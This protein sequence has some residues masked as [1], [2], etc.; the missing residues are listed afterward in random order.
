MTAMVADR[1]GMNRVGVKRSV[2][3]AGL[4]LIVAA[5][6]ATP[7]TA[8]DMSGKGG[9]GILQSLDGDL[10]RP[11]ALAFR[12]WRTAVA[13]EVL[14]AVDWQRRPWPADDLRETQAGLG[15]LV[16]LLDARRM[17]VSLGMRVWARYSWT[18][19]DPVGEEE[20]WLGLLVEL[21]LQAELFLSD[22]SS[23]VVSFGPSLLWSNPVDG[24]RVDSDAQQSD[25]V[26]TEGFGGGG[27]LIRMGGG[28][29]GGIGYTYYF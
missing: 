25:S 21:P 13:V 14:A 16:R 2:G 3:A 20:S 27:L 28:H 8:R 17:S 15:L 18:I 19:S 5:L 1:S 26:P 23:I 12:Y 11:P 7:A 10:L 22:H 4:L 9:F 6:A 29:G 24:S